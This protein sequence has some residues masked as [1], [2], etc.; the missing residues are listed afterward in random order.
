MRMSALF[1]VPGGPTST[2]VL[3][4]DD[5]DEQEADDLVLA[6]EARLERA[7]ER[8]QA[9]GRGAVIGRHALGGGKERLGDHCD[10]TPDKRPR[11]PPVAIHLR[12]TQ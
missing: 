6:E 10:H 5:R 4:G 1:A 2:A 11:R 9:L 7:R 3:A 8:A 12:F